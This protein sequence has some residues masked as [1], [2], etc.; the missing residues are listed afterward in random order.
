MRL[1]EKGTA[2][3]IEKKNSVITYYIQQNCKFIIVYRA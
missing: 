3:A 1:I 2:I